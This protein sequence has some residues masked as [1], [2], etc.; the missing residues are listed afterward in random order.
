[1]KADSVNRRVDVQRCSLEGFLGRV[2]LFSGLV[3]MLLLAV[4]LGPRWT[5]STLLAQQPAVVAEPGLAELRVKAALLYNFT[6]FVNWPSNS[7]PEPDA[8]MKVLIVGQDPFGKILEEAFAG[9][10]AS[11]HS[12][13]IVRA[14]LDTMPTNCHLAFVAA[15]EDKQCE[16][17]LEKLRGRGVLTVSDITRFADRGG[18][19]GIEKPEGR[20]LLGVR[21]KLIREAGMS[22]SSR[23]LNL[24]NVHIV[25][26]EPPTTGG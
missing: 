14:T 26:A 8:P 5:E 24:K 3:L 2:R 9:K 7:F 10:Q 23:M 21:L 20:I 18:M 6:L 13:E 12:L 1:M 25:G 17:V 19:I 15:S 16:K 4:A 11:G 22:V